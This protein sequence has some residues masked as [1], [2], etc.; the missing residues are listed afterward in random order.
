MN[1]SYSNER[2]RQ[3]TSLLDENHPA[4][5][6]DINNF[7]NQ[8]KGNKKAALFQRDEDYRQRFASG[9]AFVTFNYGIDGVSVEISKYAQILDDLFAPYEQS[10]IHL[11]GGDFYPQADSVLKPDWQR[12]KLEGIDGWDKWDEGK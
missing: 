11:I 10:G 12:F 5:W 6:K 7:L 9:S 8:V 4:D 2:Y 1:S 3:L